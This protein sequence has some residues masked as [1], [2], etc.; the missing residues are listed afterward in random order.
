M[1]WNV[2][3]AASGSCIDL[4]YFSCKKKKKKG[5]ENSLSVEENSKEEKALSLHLNSQPE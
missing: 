5:N 4:F 3:I 2:N 1:I